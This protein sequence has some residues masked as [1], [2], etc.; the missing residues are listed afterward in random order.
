LPTFTPLPEN[1][2]Q[3]VVVPP[4]TASAAESGGLPP[5]VL[6]IGLGVMGGLTLLLGVIR[7]LF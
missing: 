7:R 2:D 5:A 4:A 1:G 3:S 6:I